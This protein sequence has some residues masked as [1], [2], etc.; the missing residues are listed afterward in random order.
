MPSR[1]PS[2]HRRCHPVRAVALRREFFPRRAAH[3]DGAALSPVCLYRRPGVV[4]VGCRVTVGSCHDILCRAPSSLPDVVAR[5]PDV[6]GRAPS[7]LLRPRWSCAVVVERVPLSVVVSFGSP[8]RSP[9]LVIVLGRAP[10]SLVVPVVAVGRAP[11]SLP[12]RRWSCAV[13][14]A[15]RRCPDVVGRASS[16]LSVSRC[17][18]WCPSGP[19]CVRRRWW[20]SLVVPRRRWS[21]PSSSV[22]VLSSPA[23]SRRRRPCCVV[24]SR[25]AVACGVQVALPLK[26][27]D[28]EKPRQA[29]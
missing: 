12:R 21:C 23:V 29:A 27:N 6:V 16:S 24:V 28:G 18:W 15:G 1:L 22:V 20:S 5:C 2:R 25:R 10:A 14:V 13:V 3:V 4:G 11:S 17:P 26:Q 9:S 8:G 7:S 19:P